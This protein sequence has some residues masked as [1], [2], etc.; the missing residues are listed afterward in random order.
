MSSRIS[1]PRF[2][3]TLLAILMIPVPLAR[4]AEGDAS[5]TL[6]NGMRVHLV[7]LGGEKEVAVVLAVRAG[8][9]AEPPG[10]PHL[11]HV[12]EHMVVFGA[13]SETDE[14][15]A[16]ARWFA[17]G[18]ANAETLADWMYFDLW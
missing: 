13:P 12:T 3:R 4:A 18:K 8:A 16:V 9:F 6:P 7:P 14:G 1:V 2:A 17:G 5:D 10:R 15:K 11:A